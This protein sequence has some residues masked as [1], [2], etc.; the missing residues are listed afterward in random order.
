MYVL[1]GVQN[2]LCKKPSAVA[3]GVLVGVSPRLI[4]EIF[5]SYASSDLNRDLEPGPKIGVP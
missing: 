1:L 2:S 3:F 4:T 5:P